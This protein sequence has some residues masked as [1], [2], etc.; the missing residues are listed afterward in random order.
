MA[1]KTQKPE[2][3]KTKWMT[4]RRERLLVMQMNRWNG[5]A[6]LARKKTETPEILQASPRGRAIDGFIRSSSNPFRWGRL[7]REKD[8]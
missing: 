7:E 6:L 4:A 1:L 3:A 2:I 5:S 8:R